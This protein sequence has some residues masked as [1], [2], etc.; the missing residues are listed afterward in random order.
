MAKTKKTQKE[1]LYRKIIRA[2][3]MKCTLNHHGLCKH[4]YYFGSM[5]SSS[6]CS[7]KINFRDSLHRFLK[8]LNIRAKK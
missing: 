2:F 5:C 6:L 8:G 4:P 3:E 7:A 1:I